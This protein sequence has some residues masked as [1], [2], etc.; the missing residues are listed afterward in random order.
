M[1]FL[2]IRLLPPRAVIIATVFFINL[3]H[4]KRK[5]SAR[6]YIRFSNFTNYLIEIF[7]RQ[8]I[9]RSDDPKVIFRKYFAGFNV[10][11]NVDRPLKEFTFFFGFLN[12]ILHVA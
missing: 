5:W 6:F 1:F 2:G 9:A 8:T 10:F 7:W 3:D 4:I 12:T 11:A